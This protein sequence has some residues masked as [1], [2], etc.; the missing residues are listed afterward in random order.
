MGA[1]SRGKPRN[2]I[3]FSEWSSK[4]KVSNFKQPLLSSSCERQ[5]S[6][7]NS[8]VDRAELAVLNSSVDRAELA[9]SYFRN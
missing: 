9:T 6:V 2:A 7:L 3:I 4:V 5:R 8:S 1:C